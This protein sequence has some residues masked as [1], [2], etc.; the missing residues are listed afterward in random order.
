MLIYIFLEHPVMNSEQSAAT[1]DK[2]IA[3]CKRRGFVYQSAEIYGGLNGVYDFGHLGVLLKQ[4]IRELWKKSLLRTSPHILFFEGAILGPQALWDASGHSQ[5]FHDP[6]VDC[7]SCK[8]RYRADDIDLNNPCP[9]CGK[10]AWTAVR[11]FNMMFQTNLG[12]AAE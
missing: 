2:I 9:H 1:L 3:L 6:M 4:N 12:A 8:H 5:H 10:K 7:T 11:T